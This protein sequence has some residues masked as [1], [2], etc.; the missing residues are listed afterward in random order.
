MFST[1]GQLHSV[2][3]YDVA[4]NVPAFKIPVPRFSSG[5]ERILVKASPIFAGASGIAFSQIR[6]NRT[7]C[8]I[9]LVRHAKGPPI[10]Y[11]LAHIVPREVG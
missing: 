5:P 6:A 9:K 4:Y 11:Q 3:R 2:R 8:S 10:L 7:G 1:G